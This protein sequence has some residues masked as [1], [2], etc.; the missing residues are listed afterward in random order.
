MTPRTE[1]ASPIPKH[2]QDDLD[3]FQASMDRL[4]ETLDPPPP[5]QPGTYLAHTD[6]ACLG[7]PDG[8]GGW[9]SSIETPDGSKR[10][11]LWGHLR[12][13]SNN[14]A[15][16]LAV[17]AAVEWV[18]ARSTLVVRSDSEYTV[19][20]LKGLYKAKANRDI[21]DAL[22]ATIATKKLVVSPEW[23][24]GHAGHEG[25]ERADRLAVLGATN[26]DETRAARL[27]AAGLS[28]QNRPARPTASPA[29]LP[30]ALQGLAP[31]GPWEE[32]FVQ[33]VAKQLRAG[34]PMSEK[35]QSVL[36]RIRAR[37]AAAS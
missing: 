15:E 36:D 20:V 34:K 19:K 18:P 24:R 17:M 32:G 4:W 9:G 16:V 11:D 5:D 1:P 8:P 27:R 25:N 29:A 35:Q 30:D 26:G 33:S 10:W 14:R 12:S 2:G 37:G 13:T 28:A 6:G 7:N 23:V 3:Q 22:K 21:W 31:R